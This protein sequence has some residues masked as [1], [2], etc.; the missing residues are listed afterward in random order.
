LPTEIPDDIR[1]AP[2]ALAMRTDKKARG[3]RINFVCITG[4]GTTRLARLSCDEI[5][6][7]S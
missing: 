4:I 6:K 2:L 7:Y 5:V 1:G 3:G